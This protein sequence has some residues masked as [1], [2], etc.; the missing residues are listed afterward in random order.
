MIYA[1]LLNEFRYTDFYPDFTGSDSWAYMISF[2]EPI[3][4]VEEPEVFM[5]EDE[6]GKFVFSIK[7]TGE[8]H[9]LINSYFATESYKVESADIQQVK[10]IYKAIL[11]SRD[12]KLIIRAK[13]G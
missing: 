10:D 11:N 4:V 6:F 9:L 5:I 12:C 3:E 7:Q 1:D 2:N 13:E 8:K